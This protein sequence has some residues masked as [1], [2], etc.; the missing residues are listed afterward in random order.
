MLRYQEGF[1]DYQRVLD[2]QQSLFVQQGRYVDQPWSCRSEPW[3]ICTRRWVVVGRFTV[4][5]YDVSPET[6]EEMEQRIELG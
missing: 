3:W 5:T 1:S 4:V 6:Q 2:A